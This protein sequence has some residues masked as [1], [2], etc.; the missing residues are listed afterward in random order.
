M[1]Y[2]KKRLYQ[3]AHLVGPFPQKDVRMIDHDH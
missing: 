2:V 3:L 1:E